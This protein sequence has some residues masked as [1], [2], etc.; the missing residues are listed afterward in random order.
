MGRKGPLPQSAQ[1]RILHQTKQGRRRPKPWPL[2]PRL[3]PCPKH[4]F[5]YG[6]QVWRTLGPQLVQQG[7]L[8]PL[9]ANLFSMLCSAWGV[10]LE[11]EAELRALEPGSKDRRGLQ[12]LLIAQRRQ[13]SLLASEFGLSPA[14]KARVQNERLP[15]EAPS[16]WD[17]FPSKPTDPAAW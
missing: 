14:G 15:V 16:A 1:V 11:L 13:V 2:E 5:G 6:R 17:A 10:V 8:C 7:L 4:L 9:Y 12:R 3:P